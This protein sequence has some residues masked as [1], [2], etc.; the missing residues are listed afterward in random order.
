LA[1]KDFDSYLGHV[2]PLLGGF[3]AWLM[4]GVSVPEMRTALGLVVFASV[5]SS[6]AAALWLTGFGGGNGLGWR[7]WSCC[8]MDC[9]LGGHI[10]SLAESGAQDI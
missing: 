10:C 7:R 9:L 1:W 4:G 2:G 3:V 6:M 5:V 8:P